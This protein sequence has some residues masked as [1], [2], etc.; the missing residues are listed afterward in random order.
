[1]P[2]FGAT[3]ATHIQPLILLQ[4]RAIRLISNAGYLDNTEPLFKAQ[5]ILKLN[6]LYNHNVACYVFKN[7]NILDS[8]SVT[9]NHNTRNN[10]MF[11]PPFERLR[12]TSQ[13]VIFNG[14]RI[15]NTI[16]DN[17]RDCTTI[18]SFNNRYKQHLLSQYDS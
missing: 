5:Q 4:K 1:M 8:F 7:R 10:N 12:S 13:S 17:I 9:H 11:L 14:I 3:Y 18:D 15:W 2:I 6:D 16:P